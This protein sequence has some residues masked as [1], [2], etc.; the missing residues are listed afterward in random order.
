MTK[1]KYLC[2]C[3]YVGNHPEKN[4]WPPRSESGIDVRRM[5]N[6]VDPIV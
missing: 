2:A 6:E 4:V 1:L 3:L 5:P